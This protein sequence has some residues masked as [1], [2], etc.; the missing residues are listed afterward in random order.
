[1][2]LEL[3]PLVRSD[4]FFI[5]MSLK[6]AEQLSFCCVLRPFSKVGN[7]RLHSTPTD[8]LSF[9]GS[10]WSHRLS[11][12]L[13]LQT[14]R[15]ETP[16]PRENAELRWWGKVKN[17]LFWIIGM[18]RGVCVCV[19]VCVCVLVELRSEARFLIKSRD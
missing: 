18:V 12:S 17:F 16:N 1:M 3:P 19:C 6:G 14:A 10:V 11:L 5:F 9:Y 4:V 13:A 8:Y 2:S 15:P 7:S